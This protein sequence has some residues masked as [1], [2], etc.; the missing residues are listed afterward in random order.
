MG[1]NADRLGQVKADAVLVELLFRIF[2]EDG[3]AALL[4]PL[5]HGQYPFGLQVLHLV[6]HQ[7][8]QIRICARQ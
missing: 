6:E 5:Q 3:A 4:Q 2:Q 1:V 7:Q 8:V